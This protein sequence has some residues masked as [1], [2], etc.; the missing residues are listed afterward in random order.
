MKFSKT[1]DCKLT[2]HEWRSRAEEAAANHQKLLDMQA[3]HKV[4]KKAMKQAED[5]LES[6]I[7]ETLYAVRTGVEE[8]EVECELVPDLRTDEMV[9]VRLDTGDEIERRPMTELEQK[10]HRQTGLDLTEQE[11]T[12]IDATPAPVGEPPV[13]APE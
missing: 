4:Q 1:L 3:E 13:P 2:K 11:A 6:R 8:R 7:R 12:S 9:V 10:A 5:S